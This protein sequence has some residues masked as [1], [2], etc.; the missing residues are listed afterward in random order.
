LLGTF[1]SLF[2]LGGVLSPFYS[3]SSHKWEWD[4]SVGMII[5][6]LFLGFCAALVMRPAGLEKRS[7]LWLPAVSGFISSFCVL[8]ITVCF[9]IYLN[10]S[11][12]HMAAWM[13]SVL[14]ISIVSSL[15]SATVCLV[16]GAIYFVRRKTK[17]GGPTN[18]PNI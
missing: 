3:D 1:A 14:A 10:S 2:I 13:H 7:P 4:A 12:S 11:A 9:V 16:S 6:G 8:I 5:F 15:L 18:A 17:S